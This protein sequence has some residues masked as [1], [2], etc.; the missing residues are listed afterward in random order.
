MRSY[1]E[2]EYYRQAMRT[3]AGPSKP[4]EPRIP[5]M[6]VL[7]DFQFFN[8]PRLTEIYEKEVKITLVNF[9]GLTSQNP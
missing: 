6:P 2:A 4:R 7:H 1:S 8:I 3:G 5:R 9:I